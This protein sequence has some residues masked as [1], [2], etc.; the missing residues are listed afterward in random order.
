MFNTYLR[1][2]ADDDITDEAEE[3]QEVERSPNAA[4]AMD[5][6]VAE[7]ASDEQDERPQQLRT[8]PFG[9]TGEHVSEL[10][11]GTWGLSG[12]GYG[13]VPH[14]EAARVIERAVELGVTLFDTAD[15]YGAG[16]IE[17]EL[18]KRL[19]PEHKIVT[20]LGTFLDDYPP[21]KRFDREALASA[22]ERSRDRIGREKLDVVL[23]HNPSV[24]ALE[25]GECVELLREKVDG[26]DLCH[27]G[28]SCGSVEVAEAAIELGANVIELAYNILFQADLHALADQV[29]GTET[30]VLAR[31]VL[32]HGLLA[33]QWP[34][35]REFLTGDHRTER[36]TAETLRYRIDQLS[37]VRH[38]VDG[39]VLTM[40]GAAVRFVLANEL[41]SSAVL[42]PRSVTHLEQLMREVG[43]GPPYLDATALEDL[44]ARLMMVGIQ[45]H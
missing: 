21:R 15:V 43:D 40:R 1:G 36:W 8:R 28:V 24:A 30:A 34:K 44:P 7:P 6:P 23:L 27:W 42:G 33:G 5:Q 4:S 25:A 39:D 18:G 45:V 29:A 26:G 38:L 2:M 12:D 17:R 16:K 32:A 10:A 9:C 22:F 35:S 41:V 37:A 13:S 31:S 20:K 11:L 14:R 19:A 3:S